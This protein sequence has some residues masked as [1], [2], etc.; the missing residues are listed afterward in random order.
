MTPNKWKIK[1]KSR[2]NQYC[3]F[4][5]GTYQHL[6]LETKFDEAVLIERYRLKEKEKHRAGIEV[7]HLHFEMKVEF[8]KDFVETL[9]QTYGRRYLI[10]F[11]SRNF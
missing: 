6:Q 11:V 5:T 8:D 9:L 10:P 3:Q 1:G 2:I 4:D 7:E